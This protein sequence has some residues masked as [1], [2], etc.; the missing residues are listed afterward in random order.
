MSA[1]PSEPSPIDSNAMLRLVVDAAPG[2]M[3]YF[4]A[5]TM[6]CRFANQ[7]YANYYGLT[8]SSVLNKLPW[9]ILGQESWQAIAPHIE[10]CLRGE[11]VCY[12]RQ[13]RSPQGTQREMEVRLTPH[14]EQGVLRGAVVQVRD[15][16]LDR[17]VEQQQRESEERM[18]KFSEATQEAIVL[19]RNGL[20]IDANPALLR[21]TGYSLDELRGQSVINHLGPEYWLPAL[22]AMNS[23]K[24]VSYEV[25]VRHK[26]GHLIPM[27]LDARAMP[28]D[29]GAQDYRLVVLRDITQRH[30]DRAQMRFLAHH[31]ALTGLPNRL[32]LTDQLQ[33]LIASAKLHSTHVSVLCLDL[34]RF[35]TINDSLGHQAGDQVLCEVAQRLRSCV[36]STDLVARAG[37]DEFIVVLTGGPTRAETEIITRQVTTLLEMPCHVADQQ[38]VIATSIGIAIFPE[39]GDSAE[40][41]LRNA[42]AARNLAKDSGRNHHQFYTPELEGRASRMLNQEQLL[43]QAIALGGFELHYQPLVRTDNSALAGFEALVRWRHPQRGLV[44]P[45]EFVPFAESRGLITAID[46]WVLRQACSQARAWHA[47]GLPRVPVAVN[48]S[49]LEFRHHNLAAEV[50][51]VLAE[52]GLPP[53]LLHLELTESTLMQ[54]DVQVQHT[55]RALQQLGVELAIDDFGTGYSSL[56]Y[57][58]RHPIHQLKIDRSFVNDIAESD[59]D[60]AIVKAIVQMAHSLRLHTVAE[61]VE[62]AAQFDRLRELGCELV[63]GFHIAPPMAAEEA[64]QW[65]TKYCHARQAQ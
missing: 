34:D 64:R 19:H 50:A 22:E 6:R 46:R 7:G 59:D 47:L 10:R 29:Q 45:E 4:E 8:P 62:T 33:Q 49:A 15:L 55:L 52:T 31:D 27:E 43:R 36:R 65:Q 12:T 51:T 2:L 53:Q 42:G 30:R 58:K 54:S 5:G 25:T 44:S 61:G 60:A 11:Y 32:Y 24:D 40:A 18:R 17:A 23:G 35:T 14:L 16:S 1:S 20:I 56:A 26:D 57:L 21:M 28:M 38:L 41:L 63:Q 13:A 3:A 9:E 48:M 39:D 37:S